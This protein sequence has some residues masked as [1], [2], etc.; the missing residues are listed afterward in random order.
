MWIVALTSSYLCVSPWKDLH[1]DS[2]PP[3]APGGLENTC[4]KR[5]LYI[6]VTQRKIGV[7]SCIVTIGHNTQVLLDRYDLIIRLQF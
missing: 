1:H 5:A 6:C 3:L 7:V 2:Y 4:M